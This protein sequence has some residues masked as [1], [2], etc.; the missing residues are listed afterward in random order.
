MYSQIRSW[1]EVISEA[2]IPEYSL[3]KKRKLG[4][5]ETQRAISGVTIE[6][7]RTDSVWRSRYK[8]IL[9]TEGS[10][11]L[12]MNTHLAHRKD[13]RCRFRG[14]C[15]LLQLTNDR[16]VCESRRA[17][18]TCL[19]QCRRHGLNPK[20]PGLLSASLPTVSSL[21]Y[22]RALVVIGLCR[23]L[24][25]PQKLSW[26]WTWRINYIILTEKSWNGTFW[27]AFP[28]FAFSKLM[29]ID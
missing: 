3:Y 13:D 15:K 5:T 4:T 1:N 2:P 20:L 9:C 21:A 8:S 7:Q 29:L 27:V 6:T 26:G 24:Y 22:R 16:V 10:S 28:N 14:L 18:A 23:T 11:V 17:Q 19:L 25:S 12:E